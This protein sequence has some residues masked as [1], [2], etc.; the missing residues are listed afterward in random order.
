MRVGDRVRLVT[1]ENERLHGTEAKIESLANWGV[2]L[3]CARRAAVSLTVAASA[4]AASFSQ[5]WTC[6]TTFRM[7]ATAAAPATANA[8]QRS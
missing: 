3:P 5:P 6:P 1:P 2:K 7:E 4:S 8:A